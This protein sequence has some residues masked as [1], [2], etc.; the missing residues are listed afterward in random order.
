MPLKKKKT[1]RHCLGSKETD[2]PIF[3]FLI[4]LSHS[5]GSGAVKFRVWKQFLSAILCAD[6]ICTRISLRQVTESKSL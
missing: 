4:C 3:S 6:L 2:K 1:Q 5:K